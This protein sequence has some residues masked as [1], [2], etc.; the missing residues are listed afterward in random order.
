MTKILLADDMAHFLDLEISFLRRADCHIITAANGIE[1]LKLAKIEKP[2]IILLDI[3]MP[4]MTGV[5]CCRHIKNDPSLK[6]IPVIMVTATNREDESRKAGANDF[7]RK[8]IREQDFLRGI[9]K[10]VIIK[11]RE[12]RRVSIGIQVDYKKD[13]RSISAFT[14]DISNNG[15]FIITRDTLPV[16]NNIELTFSLPEVKNPLSVKGR[17]V[18]EL[19]DNQD[20]HYVG[21][22]GV[23]F[24]DLSEEESKTINTFITVSTQ[25]L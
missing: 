24:L 8:P 20:G 17:V 5:E 3:E 13:G 23:N 9:K 21:G 10:F 16:G 19:R 7:W 11:E 12:D 25:A 4:R 15:M 18:R 22:M 6:H 14:K 2:D 1:A